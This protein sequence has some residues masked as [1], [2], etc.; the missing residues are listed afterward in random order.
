MARWGPAYLSVCKIQKILLRDIESD[1]TTPSQ[2]A[3]LAKAYDALEER[4]RILRKQPLPKAVEVVPKN[5]K[6][7]EQSFTEA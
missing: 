3:S 2:R 4:K 5:K 7:H 6:M 1:K